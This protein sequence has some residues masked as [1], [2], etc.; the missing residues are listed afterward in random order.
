MRGLHSPKAKLQP[1]LGNQ[2]HF[3][4]ILEITCGEYCLIQPLKPT[5]G[6]LFQ[7]DF[8]SPDAILQIGKIKASEFAEKYLCCVPYLST[9]APH[10]CRVQVCI[11]SDS[12]CPIG[13]TASSQ[14]HMVGNLTELQRR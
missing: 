8:T 11:P 4:R 3:E 12:S 7:T 5:S 13:R 9:V 14:Q 10:G 1:F 2:R 6:P